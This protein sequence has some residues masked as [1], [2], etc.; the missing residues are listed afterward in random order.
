M[1]EE[2]GRG[3]LKFVLNFYSDRKIVINLKCLEKLLES[4]I[5]SIENLYEV[6]V[7]LEGAKVTK[8]K[9]LETTTAKDILLSTAL[10]MKRMTVRLIPKLAKKLSPAS[11]HKPKQ[12]SKVTP[13]SAK[14]TPEK[15]I[16]T[17]HVVASQSIQQ[18]VFNDK[19]ET[20]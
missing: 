14:T 10:T 1:G 16:T 3:L 6:A 5:P 7:K 12:K 20:E 4:R 17:R 9:D 11:S 2:G 18:F 15:D 8:S 13:S 19:I